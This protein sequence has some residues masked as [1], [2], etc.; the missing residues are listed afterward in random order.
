M[1]VLPFTLGRSISVSVSGSFMRARMRKLAATMCLW[2]AVASVAAR[3]AGADTLPVRAFP[4]PDRQVASIVSPIW[5]S[6]DERDA[7]KEVPQAIRLLG[8][9]PGMTVA[10]IGAGSGYYVTRLSPLL[11]ASGRIIA[12]DITPAYLRLLEAKVRDLHLTNVTI[13]TGE[14]GDP[15]LPPRALDR[16]LLI[17]MYHEIANPFALLY[18][19]A[20]SLKPGAKIGI[21]DALRPV[22]EHGTPPPLLRCEAESLGY[23]QIGFSKLDGSEAYLA[24]FEL[25][26][27]VAPH[28][29]DTACKDQSQ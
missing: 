21:V 12:E 18:N 9:E 26:A 27:G 20:G 19:L 6:E 14:P 2:A 10:D 1:R 25:P 4:P 24:V 22:L 28:L 23:R 16:A 7:A 17:H 11:G 29:P 15:K 8:I 13:I 3:P 5:H